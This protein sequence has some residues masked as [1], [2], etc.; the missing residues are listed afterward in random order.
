MKFIAFFAFVATVSATTVQ[1]GPGCKQAEKSKSYSNCGINVLSG[2][3]G[4]SD[5]ERYAV[6]TDNVEGV[7]FYQH[8]DCSGK[9]Y[10]VKGAGTNNGEKCY[11]LGRIG[12]EPKCISIACQKVSCNIIVLLF[13]VMRLI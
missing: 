7:V 3:Y 4:C 8:S 11:N 5:N 9:S 13:T 1:L 6:I 10:G 12:F 2:S